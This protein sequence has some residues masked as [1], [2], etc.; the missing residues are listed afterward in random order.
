[1]LDAAALQRH[2]LVLDVNAA[3]GLL[4][5][6]ALRRAP[7]GGVW[8]LAYDAQ[9][10]EAL[11]Q[12]AERLPDIERPGVLVGDLVQLPALLA[13]CQN[14]ELRFDAIVGRNTLT[15]YPD[16]SA[17]LA[18]LA[19]ACYAR[20]ADSRSWKSYRVTANDSQPWWT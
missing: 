2:S 14:Q 13:A 12:Q 9:A 18:H 10:G 19:H 1:M 17:A 20:T 8:A 11:R 7:E 3:S 5:W 15:K 16:K 4:T 6:E